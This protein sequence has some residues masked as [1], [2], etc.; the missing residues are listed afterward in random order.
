MPL[1]YRP[2]C[3]MYILFNARRGRPHRRPTETIKQVT[4]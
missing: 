3:R 1:P 2:A 4:P